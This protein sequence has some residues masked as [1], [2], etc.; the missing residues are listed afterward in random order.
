MNALDRA[1]FVA[2]ARSPEYQDRLQITELTVTRV[3]NRL[4]RPFVAWSGGK[5]SSALLAL[6]AEQRPDATVR[7][8]TGG[9]TRWLHADLDSLLDWWR[10]AWPSLDI[11]EIR[12]DHVAGDGWRDVCWHEQ[13]MSFHPGRLG[14]TEWAAYLHS[15]GNWDGV[16]LG[17]RSDE[18]PRRRRLLARDT[19]GLPLWRGS[20]AYNAGRWVACPLRDWSTQDVGA[21]LVTRGIPLLAAYDTGLAERTKMR[22]GRAAI[23]WGGQLAKLHG[24]DPAGHAEL[25]RRFPE[26]RRYE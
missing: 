21:L 10:A 1:G 22:T 15:A 23:H 3:L 14:V 17:L 24:R 20:D 26:L 25:V 12:V 7:I 9:E 18:S 8:L 11:D 16:L 4:D 5:D 19:D 2:H 13:Y 6:V